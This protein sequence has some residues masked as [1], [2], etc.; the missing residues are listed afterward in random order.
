MTNK[1]Q[2]GYQ[3]L[4]EDTSIRVSKLPPDQAASRA[5]SQLGKGMTPDG[6]SYLGSVA[7]HIY[8]TTADN[9]LSMPGASYICQV[10]PGIATE[11]LTIQGMEE[12]GKRLYAWFRGERTSID[13]NYTLDGDL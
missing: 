13:P 10:N 4:G 7:L 2:K 9:P 1:P 6:V 5:L 8:G 12:L 11:A 3:R